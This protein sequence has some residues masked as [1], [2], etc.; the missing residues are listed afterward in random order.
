MASPRSVGRRGLLV[1]AT[2]LAVA[3][4]VGAVV[5]AGEGEELFEKVVRPYLVERC[6]ECH[7]TH[8]ARENDL[9]LDWAG[10]M[11]TGGASGPAVVPGKPAESEIMVAL[12]HEN[13]L[14]MPKGGPKPSPEIVRAFRRWIE[15][16]APDPRVQP[17]SAEELA[18]ETSWEEIFARR[19]TWWSLQPLRTPAVP[20][21]AADPLASSGHPVDRFIAAKLAAAGIE[22]AA[23]AD[24]ETLLR[25]ACFVLTGL[26]PTPDERA[27]FLADAG[28]DR[29]ETLVDRLIASPHFAEHWARHWLDCVRYCETH[30]SEGDPVIPHAWR[31]RDWCIRAIRDDVPIDRFL[32]EQIAGDLLPDPRIDAATGT[33]ESALGIGQLRMVPHGFTPTDPLDEM[34]TFTDNQIDVLSKAFLGMTVSCARCHNHKFDAISQADFYALFGTLASCRPALIQADAPGSR[35]RHRA[36]LAALKESI[37]FRLADA[38]LAAVADPAA[39]ADALVERLVAAAAPPPE[40]AAEPSGTGTDAAQAGGK[41]DP[42]QRAREKEALDGEMAKEL[43]M[44]KARRQRMREADHPFAAALRLEGLGGDERRAVWEQLRA[45]AVKLP[46]AQAAADVPAL[47]EWMRYGERLDAS[48]P[49]EFRV[50]PDGERVIARLL[51]A[52]IHSNLLVASDG[53]MLHSPNFPVESDQI[54]LLV[55]GAGKPRFRIVVWNYPRPLGLLYPNQTIANAEPE[56]ITLKTMV[57]KGE[58]AHLELA[59]G[60][61]LAVEPVDEPRSWFSVLAV[62]SGSGPPPAVHRPA[63]SLFDLLPADDAVLAGPAPDRAA[64]AAAYARAVRQAVEAWRDG[65]ATGPQ[66]RMLDV[67]VAARVLPSDLGSL[68]EVREPVERFRM[69]SKEIPPPVRAPG[70]IEGTV[71]DQPLFVRGNHKQPAAVVPRRFLE[72]LDPRPFP[73][74]TSGRRELA[75]AIVADS[76]PL[77][78]RVFVNRVWHHLFGRGIV[79]SVDTFGQMGDLPTHPELLDY[80]AA[81]F[82]APAADAAAPSQRPWSLKDLVRFLAT[83][84]TFRLAARPTE[85]SIRLDPANTLFSHAR[86][87]RL[88]GELIRDALLAAAGRLDRRFF[89]PSVPGGTP[90]RSVY[91]AVRRNAID[92]FLG[93]F[94]PPST[95]STQGRR[96]VSQVPAQA[97]VL[98]NG[99]FVRGLATERAKRLVGA[100]RDMPVDERIRRLFVEAVGR[101]PG[102]EELAATRAWL[103]ARA[104]EHGASAADAPA[105]VPLWAD[106]VHAT[107]NLEEFIHVD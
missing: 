3:C 100:W 71:V 24:P 17:P 26:P 39:G 43:A 55:A 25:R 12:Q 72:A 73:P 95:Q 58:R 78:P 34:V 75:A 91:V 23:E 36:E 105:H 98:M 1:V 99:D 94:D 96:D 41:K 89:G 64:L 68:P 69:L 13:D 83:S 81:R 31:Y 61:D 28:A 15:L 84:R 106:L 79:A 104:A 62:D 8:G 67:L 47:T 19:K 87:R 86:L 66:V 56:W 44:E 51:P 74:A 53:S 59:T 103:D 30:G 93:A 5:R 20:P 29:W 37:R 97:L 80:L 4:G 18:K 32:Q 16:D 48:P 33:N 21:P 42:Q 82:V 102:T 107:Y 90:R 45:E 101:E 49:G 54:R 52:G 50:E 60:G 10:G 2:A 38:W 92:P 35:D 88:E 22:P 11:R 40:P 76:N 65:R 77:T 57:W 63:A 6:Y 85:S 9:A 27:A 14:L 7:G 46:A 70:V